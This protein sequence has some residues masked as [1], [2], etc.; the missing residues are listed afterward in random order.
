MKIVIAPDSFKESL[1][2]FNVASAIEK[3]FKEIF[4]ETEYIKCP[5][6]DGGEGSLITM[7]EASGG[8]IISTE[9][10][11]PNGE[12]IQAYFGLSLDKN[13]AFIEIATA[14][15]LELISQ[16]KRNPL[17]ATSFG[18]GEL[19]KKALDY[20][21]T[22]FI[23]GIG[24]SAT[25][26]GGA[27]ML[28]ALGVEL[29]DING[30]AIPRGGCGLASLES[31]DMSNFDSR[32]S[33]CSFQIAC[34][35]TNPLL[36]K[37]G[38]SFIFGPQK[39]ATPEMVLKLDNNLRNFARVIQK[40]FHLDVSAVPGGGAA[41]GLGAA[42]LAFFNAELKPGFTLISETLNLESKIK[43]AHLVITG[44]GR[45]DSQSVNG[46]VPVGVAEIARRHGVPVIAISGVQGEGF[47]MVYSWGI[48]A[49]FSILNKITS[50]E[51]A[52]K[53]AETNIYNCSRNLASL[54]KISSGINVK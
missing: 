49:V 5:V 24:G 6:A 48:D 35:V 34:D 12:R 51:M 47:E 21:A 44:E 1:S 33:K 17:Y 31:I 54:I 43:G 2:A 46:K 28:Q 4:P 42:F 3:G 9:V 40:K 14:S 18:T 38:A 23:I 25:N 50:L 29:L 11:D 15:G 10:T 52:L 32:I 22:H 45:I 20:G 16:E 27:G 7:V 36:G 8:S 41:G 13:S 30:R 39:G 37:Q 53:N 26:D 19:I